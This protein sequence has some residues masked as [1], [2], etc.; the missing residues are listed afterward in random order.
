M[1]QLIGKVWKYG[2]NV[3]T[4]VIFPGRFTYT[5]MTEE[6]MGTH[7]L[8]D[9]DVN[10]IQ[11]GKP[12]DIIV[13]GRNWG[14]GSAREQAVKCLKARGVGALIAKGLSRIYYRNCL[15]EGLPI[16]VCPEA[17]DAIDAGQEITVDFETHTVMCPSGQFKFP[18]YPDYVMGLV[19]YGGLIPFVQAKL[20]REGR[21]RD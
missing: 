20:R 14:C 3:N 11:S 17:V 7:A 13:G 10:F 21:L 16:I 9:L 19:E 6:E 12:G 2:D 5:L 1:K 15:N 8:E 4:D 18:P